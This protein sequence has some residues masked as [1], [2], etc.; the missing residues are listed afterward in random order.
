M[1]FTPYGKSLGLVDEKGKDDGR[2]VV[3]K[4]GLNFEISEKIDFLVNGRWFVP[5]KSGGDVDVMFN[6]NAGL[7]YVF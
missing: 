7:R 4:T 1:R 3:L 2:F 6:L 5:T